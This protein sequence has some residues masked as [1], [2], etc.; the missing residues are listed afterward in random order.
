MMLITLEDDG[1]VRTYASPEEA[2][3]KVEALDAEEVFR[4]VFDETG[5]PYK[6]RWIRPNAVGRFLV[7]NG[8]YTL[9]PEG[10]IDPEGLIQ[11][12]REARHVDPPEL[13]ATLQA[14]EHRLAG[15]AER[16]APDDQLPEA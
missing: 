3:Q 13:I 7:S 10:A 11:I 8:R 12:I 14:I 4:A 1:V 15:C 2:V 5:Q 6:I 16:P 9:A